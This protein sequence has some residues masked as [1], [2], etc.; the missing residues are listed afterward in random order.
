[1]NTN[2]IQEWAQKIDW[3]KRTKAVCKP[4]WELKY[5]PYGGLV[6]QFPI[7]G[8]TRQQAIKHNEFLKSQ[9]K[10]GAYSG[11][12][13]ELFEKEVKNFN[14][15]SYP[16]TYSKNDIS[17]QCIIFGHQCPVYYTNEP[18]TETKELRNISRS[19]PRKVQFQVLKRDNQICNDCENSVKEEN[20]EFDHIIPWSKGGCSDEHNVKLLCKNCNRKKS[21]KFEDKYCVRSISEHFKKRK[22]S[23]P[24]TF[25]QSIF[26][27]MRLLLNKYNLSEMEITPVIFCKLFGRRKV[28]EEDILGVETFNDISSFFTGKRPNELRKD[29]FLALKYRWGYE[30]NTFHTIIETSKKFKTSKEDIYNLDYAFIE[31]LGFYPKIPEKEKKK[32]LME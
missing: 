31:R 20:I 5:C 6:E 32:W 14:Q 7:L 9:L 2:P 16:P 30:D 26:T 4:C 15:N 24:F 10:K 27:I 18:L 25:V 8:P 13:K 21:N 23:V 1:M 11:W 29:E 3:D 12:R 28:K 17:K 19:I 22:N